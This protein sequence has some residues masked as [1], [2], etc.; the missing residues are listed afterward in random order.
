MDFGH[1]LVVAG[2]Q[3][4]E[5]LGEPLPRLAVDPAHDAEIDRGDRAI[6]FHEQVALVHVGMEIAAA[7]RLR[8][9]GQHQAAG[10]FLAIVAG[11]VDRFQVADLDAVDPVE[12]HHPAIGAVPVDAGHAIA[13]KG[14]HGIGQFRSAGG[15]AAQVHLAR[16]PAR[17]LAMTRRGRRRPASPPSA[18]RC[19]AAHS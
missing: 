11:R 7:D 17:K 5:Y 10:H 4:I 3:A 6:G 1:A 8:E 15:L 19:A 12:R 2:G 14:M 9:E 18:S 16:G 13:G